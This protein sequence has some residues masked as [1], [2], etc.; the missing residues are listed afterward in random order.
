[1]NGGAL[2]PEINITDV[3]ESYGSTYLP[4]YRRILSQYCRPK[5]G[6]F[7]EWGAGHTT[8]VMIDHLDRIGCNK[9][10][11]IDDYRPYLEKVLESLPARPWLFSVI[12][13]R[14]GLMRSQKDP[15]LAY[16]THPLTYG[17][18]FDYIYIDGRRRLECAAVSALLCH[19]QTI[20]VVHDY[21]RARYQPMRLIFDIVE[22]GVQFR[23]MKMRPELQRLADARSAVILNELRG[24][25]TA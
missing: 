5:T 20:I 21:L 23:V 22:D 12:A 16:S 3:S 15:E 13:S 9:F 17:E 6:Y 8:A 25:R 4:E 14:E 24:T 10:V 7:L 18:K 1:M 19:S 2:M 11:C